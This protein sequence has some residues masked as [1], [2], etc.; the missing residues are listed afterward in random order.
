M[1]DVAAAAGVSH[2][3][4]SRVINGKGFVAQDTRER[5][6][7]AIDQLGYRPN[8]MA[9]ALVTRRSGIIGVVTST[10]VH[11]GPSSALLSVELAARERGYFTG[12]API[13]E[14]TG[15]AFR[16][17]LDHFLGLNAEGIVIIAPF[18][19][20][21]RDFAEID[22]PVPVVAITSAR[23]GD[24]S[25]VISVSV[26]QAAGARQA[27]RHLIDLGHRD[28]AHVRGPRNWFEAQ[29]REAAW[30]LELSRAGLPVREP[31]GGEWSASAGYEAGLALADSDAV[32]TAVFAAN[33]ELALGV[34]RAFRERG[35]GVPGDVSVV[36]FDDS[37]ST[38]YFIP[39]L[40]SVRQDFD[41]LGHE[42]MR[43]MAEAIAGGTP[44]RSV[45]LPAS[46]VVRESTAAP[47]PV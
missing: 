44:E 34:I 3:T 41:A 21:A 19:D 32:P 47:R 4:V 10:S 16:T 25:G 13:Q 18:E 1:I 33:D 38:A 12:V 42:V 8:S 22:V 15:T 46:L 20:A 40:T 39:A 17:A 11:Y 26:D 24:V 28:I 31:L 30:R 27:V 9:R 6:L 7:K 36:G 14:Y 35:V 43:V 2:Q 5:V 37:P 29:S 23:L 45:A